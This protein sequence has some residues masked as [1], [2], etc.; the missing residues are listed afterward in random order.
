MP[1]IR[2]NKFYRYKDLT[3]ILYSYAEEFPQLVSIESIVDTLR[4]RRAKI[5]S[6]RGAQP[7]YPR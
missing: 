5:L 7:L 3:R 1:E 2:F 4:P 6:S